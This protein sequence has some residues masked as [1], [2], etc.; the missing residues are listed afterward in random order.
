MAPI[1]A[2]STH[3]TRPYPPDPRLPTG[4]NQQMV[5]KNMGLQCSPASNS[6]ASGEHSNLLAPLRRRLTTSPD[7]PVFLA[8]HT[9]SNIKGGGGGTPHGVFDIYLLYLHCLLEQKKDKQRSKHVP[10][11][12]RA[13]RQLLQL[14]N[15]ELAYGF[16]TQFSY[17]ERSIL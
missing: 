3:V 4:R 9:P 7:K 15:P 14:V 6:E 17:S 11:S 13:F 12:N 5:K 16:L 2:T 10:T 1:A 8:G